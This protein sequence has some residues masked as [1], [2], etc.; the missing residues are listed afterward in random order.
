MT[1]AH[2]PE[3][4]HHGPSDRARL[5]P[6]GR[7]QAEV[8]AQ[9]AITLRFDHRCLELNER[10]LPFSARCDCPITTTPNRDVV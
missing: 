5:A 2:A 1:F 4:F 8:M 7:R 6:R 10:V 3:S 9:H